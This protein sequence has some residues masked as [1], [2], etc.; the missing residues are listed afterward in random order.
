MDVDICG[1]VYDLLTSHVSVHVTVQ[2]PW[3]WLGRHFTMQLETK[4]HNMPQHEILRSCELFVEL[5]G[6]LRN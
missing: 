2:A 5:F 4:S 6:G 3:P 1:A